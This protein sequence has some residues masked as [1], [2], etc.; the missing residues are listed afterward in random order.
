MKVR[1]V[2]SKKVVTTTADTS[3]KEVSKIVF[4]KKIQAVPVVDGKGKLLGI[5]AEGDILAKMYPS[6]REFVEDFTSASDFE[7]MEDGLKD[8]MKLKVK[9]IM[10]KAVVCTYPDA[11]LL[12]AASKMMVRR[13]GRLP[14]IDPETGKLL[15][16]ISKGDVIRAIIKFHKQPLE[17]ILEKVS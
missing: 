12:K 2:M 3:I 14:V 17:K 7:G 16:V 5:V 6:Q 10:N 15:G 11:P 1:D 8:V 13:V 9:D 4:S